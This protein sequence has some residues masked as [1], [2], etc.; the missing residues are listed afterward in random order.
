MALRQILTDD[1]QILRKVSREVSVF[2]NRLE[3]LVE[4]MVETMYANNGIGLA[5]PQVG[6]LRRIFVV[7]I[8]DGAGVRVMVNPRIIAAEGSQLY[9]EG[10]LSV[11]DR[12]GE[13][14]RPASLVL[15]AQDLKGEKYRLEADGLLAVCI[16]H[17]NDH[18]DGILFLDKVRGEVIEQ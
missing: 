8:Q 3:M 2:D 14:E 15:E 12:Y 6:I 16:S 11:P 18:L 17:E 5:A 9:C 13:V 7:D 4:D 10:C 1:D